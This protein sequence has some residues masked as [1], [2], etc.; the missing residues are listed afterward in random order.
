M[1]DLSNLLHARFHRLAGSLS[2]AIMIGILPAQAAPDS[3]AA[4]SEAFCAAVV[5]EDMATMAAL[6]TDDA[7]SYGPGGDIVSGAAAIAAS[8]APFFDGFDNLTCALDEAGN[9]VDGETAATWGLWTM[10]GVPP[11][12]GEP[13]VMK[14]RYTDIMVKFEDGWRYRVDHASMTGTEQ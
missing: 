1:I 8:W 9:L 6:Y 2:G 14:G 4:L 10:T 3:P 13:I 5:A 12:G 7:D 11:G